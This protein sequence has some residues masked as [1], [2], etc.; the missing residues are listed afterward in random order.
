MPRYHFHVLDDGFAHDEEGTDLPSAL[1]ARLAATRLAGE[2]V[3]ERPQL[4]LD[5]GLLRVE[6]TDNAGLILFSVLV[7]A[8]DAPALRGLVDPARRNRSA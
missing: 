3:S 4:V 5:T 6:V 7:L 8:N 1:H 2:L